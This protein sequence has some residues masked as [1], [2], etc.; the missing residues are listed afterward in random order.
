MASRKEPASWLVRSVALVGILA[1]L[2]LGHLATSSSATSLLRVTF[3]DVGQGDAAWL[4][5]PD[6]WDV[7]IDGG[8]ESAGADLVSYLQSQGVADIEVMVLTHPHADHVGGL[9]AVLESLEV[10]LVL[11][12]CQDYPTSI[13]Q[14]FKNLIDSEAI[15]LSCVRDGDSYTWGGY[16]TAVAVHPP[17][18]LIS[19]SGSDVNNNSLV[20]RVTLGTVDFLF[21]GDIEGE[22]E[23]SILGRSETVDAEVLKVAHHGSNSSSTMTFLS[24]V[25]ADEA[26][27]SV[28]TSNPYGHPGDEA[29][30]R[31]GSAEATLYRTDLHGTILVETDGASYSVQ[32]QRTVRAHMPL[33]VG[34]FW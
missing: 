30:Q 8:P 11:S 27:I 24:A 1:L 2:C 29:L 7:L 3:M 32:P 13:Y 9:V 28:G 5:T 17:E 20:F 34:S 18:P 15:S 12:S 14:E 10:Y 33:I 21:T 4:N 26:I 23:S 19:G 31:L 22:A 16:V 6:G 25:G